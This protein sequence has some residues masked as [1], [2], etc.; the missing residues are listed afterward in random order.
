MTEFESIITG[1]LLGWQIGIILVALSILCSKLLESIK[2][3]LSKIQYKI[4]QKNKDR[5]IKEKNKQEEERK[6]GLYSGN[7]FSY[8]TLDLAKE[9]YNKIL[10]KNK[11]IKVS[12]KKFEF[13]WSKDSLKLFDEIILGKN[14]IPNEI[15]Y[16]AYNSKVNEKIVNY[17]LNEKYNTEKADLFS[18]YKLTVRPYIKWIKSK[19]TKVPELYLM[20]IL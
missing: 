10:K 15:I 1:M 3:G 9:D 4:K 11:N 16:G 18:D 20:K 6:Y 13:K 2:R 19:N 17:L 14:Y 5:I 12:I 8:P 7:Q